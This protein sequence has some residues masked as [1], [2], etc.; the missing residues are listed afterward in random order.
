[1]SGTQ[2]ALLVIGGIVAVMFILI[3]PVLVVRLVVS[4]IRRV[5]SLLVS[6]GG[7]FVAVVRGSMTIRQCLVEL[8]YAVSALVAAGCLGWASIQTVIL[9]KNHWA[10]WRH[11]GKYDV[12]M[13]AGGGVVAAIVSWACWVSSTRALD[14]RNAQ[15]AED[16][17]VERQVRIH[18][19]LKERGVL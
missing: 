5:G 18:Q 17:E 9:S 19:R 12:F 14:R 15:W 3:S 16:E 13:W 8:T 1:M 10:E 4:A 2:L 6:I 11:G 7:S